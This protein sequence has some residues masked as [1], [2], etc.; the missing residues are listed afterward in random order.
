[1][2]GENLRESAR[3]PF[4]D[5]AQTCIRGALI[6]LDQGAGEVTQSSLGLPFLLGEG[7]VN[8]CLL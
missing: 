1:M 2:N 5:V 6:Y 3:R 4:I 7:T 8:V